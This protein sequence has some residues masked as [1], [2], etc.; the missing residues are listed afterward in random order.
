MRRAAPM[1]LR[2][3]RTQTCLMYRRAAESFAQTSVAN[4]ARL[5]RRLSRDIDWNQSL[6]ARDASSTSGAVVGAGGE[7]GGGSAEASGELVS[8]P[9]AMRDASELIRS[10]NY[11]AGPSALADEDSI[12]DMCGQAGAKC[13]CK[14][15]HNL[16]LQHSTSWEHATVV[17]A[18]LS[19][20]QASSALETTSSD[21][22]TSNKSRFLPACSAK[23]KLEPGDPNM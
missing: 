15:P 10:C 7:A 1:H 5:R 14:W 22:D 4:V 13:P 21:M 16:P 17:A 19:S 18:P 11:L 9:G 23:A 6:D 2:Q 20:W 12:V 8:P 3:H